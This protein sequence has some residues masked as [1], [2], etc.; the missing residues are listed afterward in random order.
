MSVGVGRDLRVTT[1][2]SAMAVV[3]HAGHRELSAS[4]VLT[5]A[6]ILLCPTTSTTWT[7]TATVVHALQLASA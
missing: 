6:T 2:W 4:A 3:A 5:G 1:I 7:D